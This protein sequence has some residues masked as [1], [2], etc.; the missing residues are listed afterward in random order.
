VIGIGGSNPSPSARV[1]AGPAP[2]RRL[3][4]A[5]I[6]ENLGLV[7]WGVVIAAVF[8]VAWRMGYLVRLSGYILETRE[9]L[10]KCTWPTVDELKGSTVLVAVAIVLLGGFIAVIDLVVIALVRLII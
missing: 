5:E 7:I 3:G 2:G 10:K 8:G 4:K 9:E 6:M 1:G